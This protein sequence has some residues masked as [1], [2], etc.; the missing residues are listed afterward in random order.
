[1]GALKPGGRSIYTR[2]QTGGFLRANYSAI[3]VP[4]TAKR[5]YT[6]VDYG[7]TKTELVESS[8]SPELV[9]EVKLWERGK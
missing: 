3:V 6:P 2:R 4:P 1:M 7:I 8:D 9:S 5:D